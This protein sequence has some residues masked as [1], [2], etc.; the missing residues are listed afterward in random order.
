VNLASSGSARE[1][2]V[3]PAFS[4]PAVV[5]DTASAQSPSHPPPATSLP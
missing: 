2:T 4:S 1:A 3:L 5:E